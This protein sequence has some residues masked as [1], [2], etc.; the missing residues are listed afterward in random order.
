MPPAPVGG[1]SLVFLGEYIM[2]NDVES[3]YVPA[4]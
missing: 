1:V 2:T 4:T 3:I